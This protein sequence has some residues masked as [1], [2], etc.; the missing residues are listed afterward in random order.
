M[1]AR[2]KPSVVYLAKA[3]IA[4]YGHVADAL[5]PE[6]GEA[7]PATTACI[8]FRSLL[9]E[10]GWDGQRFGMSE[11]NPL[12]AVI[13]PGSRVVIKPNWVHH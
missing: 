5:L 3:P 6:L 4:E 11:W 12:G 9:R 7:A 13:P 10:S 2:V 1:T 8:T